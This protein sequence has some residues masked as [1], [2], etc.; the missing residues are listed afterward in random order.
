V[1]QSDFVLCL[2]GLA[3]R[4]SEIILAGGKGMKENW[5]VNGKYKATDLKKQRVS[6]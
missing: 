5:Q 6:K 4:I 3:A 1:Q 2:R